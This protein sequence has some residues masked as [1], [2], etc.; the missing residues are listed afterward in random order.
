MNNEQMRKNLRAHVLLVPAAY[1]LD[2]YGFEL[3]TVED[4]W[5]LIEDVSDDGVKIRNP[6]SGHVKLLTYDHLYK[7]TN[8]QPKSGAK[9]GF[10][11]LHVQ[12]TVQGNLVSIVPNPRPGEAVPPKRPQVIDKLVTFAYPVE[13]GMQQRLEAQG[14]QLGWCRPENV[15]TKVDVQ[16]CSVVLEPDAQ[17]VFSTFRTRDGQVLIKCPTVPPRRG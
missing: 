16:G 9:R 17:G 1:H 14:Y 3:P 5:W 12:I 11:S 15:S 2:Q 13:T 8:D 10:L 7:W 4:P 6:R